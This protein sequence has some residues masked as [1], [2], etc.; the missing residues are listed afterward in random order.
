LTSATPV[1]LPQVEYTV[2]EIRQGEVVS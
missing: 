1:D 2:H